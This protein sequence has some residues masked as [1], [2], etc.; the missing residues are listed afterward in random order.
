MV[1][2][3][4]EFFTDEQV[5]RMLGKHPVTVRKWRTKNKDLGVIQYG[6]PYEFRGHNVVYPKS[7]FYEW[8]AKVQV[9]DGVPRMNL[10]VSSNIVV[11][12]QRQTVKGGE[13][14]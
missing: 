10:P 9:V 4:G 5:A 8:C 11:P 14:E 2:D 6:P 13:L 7:Q 3:Y 12:H 1:E